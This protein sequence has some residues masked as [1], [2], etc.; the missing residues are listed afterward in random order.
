VR[1]QTDAEVFFGEIPA[2]QWGAPAWVNETLAAA[3][4][5]KM[6]ELRF[7]PHAGARRA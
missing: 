7:V 4:R 5:E 2:E 1:L 6:S 3:N